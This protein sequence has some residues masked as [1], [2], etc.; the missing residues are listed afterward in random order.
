MK[1]RIQNNKGFTLIELLLVIAI[2]GVLSG[3]AVL[4][5]REMY[6]SYQI[7]GVARQLYSDMQ[8]ARLLAIKKGKEA[9]IDFETD[10]L[11]DVYYSPKWKVDG[12]K[13]GKL[14]ATVYLTGINS[15]YKNIKACHPTSPGT[16]FV[17]VEF[18]PNGTASTGAIKLSLSDKVYKIYV[19][20]SGT[21][22]VRILNKA[23]LLDEDPDNAD[24]CP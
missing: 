24:A 20:S 11:G 14:D 12:S 5:S 1:N 2:I 13:L 4:S 9:V 17:D 18:N 3:I 16:A 10:G 21:G 6:A 22:N 23:T 15:S 7:R 8:Y 19:S